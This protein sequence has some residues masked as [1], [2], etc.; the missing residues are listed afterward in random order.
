MQLRN[1]LLTNWVDG[2]GLNPLSHSPS[3][4]FVDDTRP[5]SREPKLKNLE[6]L[7]RGGMGSIGGTTLTAPGGRGSKLAGIQIPKFIVL[8]LHRPELEIPNQVFPPE[9]R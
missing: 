7:G 3:P 6:P 1:G 9:M 8:G 4:T 2:A 5:G